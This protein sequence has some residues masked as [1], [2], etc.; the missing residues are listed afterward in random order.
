MDVD[1][2]ALS[3]RWAH[4]LGAIVLLGGGLFLRLVMLPLLAAQSEEDR[5]RWHDLIRSKWAKLVGICTL[6]LL[7]SGLYNYLVVSVPKH[8]GDGLYHGLMGLKMLAALA[9]FFFSAALA[10]KSEKLAG[11]RRKRNLWT[12]TTVLLGTLAV[13]IA[14]YLKMRGPYAADAADVQ[15]TV[16]A[17]ASGTDKPLD[18][19]AIDAD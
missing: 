1:P 10:G 16:E 12:T 7:V 8:K 6:I 18:L 5:S 9:V 17:V 14:G 4:V 13:L 19:T 11:I 15:T 3:S 2:I